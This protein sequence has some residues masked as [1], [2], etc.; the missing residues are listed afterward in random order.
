MYHLPTSKRIIIQ[1][2]RTIDQVNEEPKPEVDTP[3]DFEPE[4]LC[5]ATPHRLDSDIKFT[6]ED[7][8][9]YVRFDN[10]A[11][12]MSDGITSVS[13]F[14][15]EFFPH[16]DPDVVIAKMRKG[17]NWETGRYVGMSTEAIKKLWDDN[18]KAASSRGTLLHFLQECQKNGYDLTYSPY[19]DILDNM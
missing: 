2:K 6:E 15:H 8:K 13:T 9:H 10:S 16:F 5:I 3:P 1:M 19:A 12:Y 11:D 14:I 7:H 17:R 4:S 18:G